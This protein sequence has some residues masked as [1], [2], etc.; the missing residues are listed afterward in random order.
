MQKSNAFWE[1][2]QVYEKLSYLLSAQVSLADALHILKQEHILSE[3]RKGKTLSNILRE[4]RMPTYIVS[5]ITQGEKTGTLYEACT[6]ISSMLHKEKEIRNKIILSLLY[7][8]VLF[9]VTTGIVI[10]LVVY[11]FPKMTP[12]FMSMKATLPFTTRTVLWVSDSLMHYWWLYI[13]IIGVL[14]SV[15]IYVKEYILF[16]VFFVKDWYITQKTSQYFSRIGS[17]I[18]SGIGLDEATQECAAMENSKF[19]KIVLVHI[20]ICV[21][22]G[23]S[24]SYV[25]EKHAIFPKEIASMIMVGENSGKLGDMCKKIGEVYEKKFSD[26]TRILTSAVEPISMLGMGLIVG[27]IA[28]SMITPLYS[29][30]QHVQ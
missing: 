1:R 24:F 5:R 4:K 30:T 8:C 9:F 3:F 28:L 14:F 21:R 29:I 22:Q 7:P 17:Y 19:F 10:F 26:Y 6:D 15:T 18:Q 25:I 11:I 23:I 20:S 2:E 13:I 16:N 12:L 27:F